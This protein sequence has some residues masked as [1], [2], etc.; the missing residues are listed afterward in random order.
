[1]THETLKQISLDLFIQSVTKK[2]KGFIPD[3]AQ[4]TR[5]CSSVHRGKI[6]KEKKKEKR[7]W[8][9]LNV[10]NIRS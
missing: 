10:T 1:M 8:T 3:I 4:G 2:K 7:N 6:C 9:Q 5:N